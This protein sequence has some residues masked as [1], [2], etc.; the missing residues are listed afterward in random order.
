MTAQK[1]VSGGT[2]M[3][4]TIAT[5][6]PMVIGVHF[7]SSTIRAARARKN[8]AHPA[9]NQTVKN[10]PVSYF[11]VSAAKTTGLSFSVRTLPSRSTIHGGG[12]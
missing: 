12:T 3:R 8:P 7:L 6:V 10:N 2:H 9:I 4:T 5:R 1:N 11:F